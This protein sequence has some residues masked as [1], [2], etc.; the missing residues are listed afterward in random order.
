M[1]ASSIGAKIYGSASVPRVAAT[2]VHEV[3]I[4]GTGF[5]GLAMAIRLKRGGRRR[6]RR[7]R[8][9][10]RRRRHL[11]GQHLP[12]LRLRRAVPPLLVLV[13]A[14]TPAGAHLLRRRP[15]SR[16]TCA[17]CADALRRAPRTCARLRAARRALGR[18]R[19]ALAARRPPTG[20]LT[21]R[22]L[23]AARRSAS[24]SPRLP[25]LPGSS[26]FR[27]TVFHSAALG[28]RPRPDRRASRWS[29]LAPPRSS[30]CRGSSRRWAAAP[31]PAHGA[32][33]DAAARPP[34]DARRAAA[35]P[36]P[37]GRAAADA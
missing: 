8:A 7:P 9:R 37:A 20:P 25:R 31:L 35:L 16:S 27:G 30:S 18:R 15:R 3:A 11:A 13:R 19:A 5:A 4:V 26:D 14:A 10:P 6:L 34:A 23:V 1:F 32:V 2:H 33:G 29:A 12:R 21:A 36:P 24:T 28:P 22:V 17:A